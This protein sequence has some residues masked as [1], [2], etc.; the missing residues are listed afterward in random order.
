MPGFDGQELGPANL[1]VVR[2]LKP[3]SG[4]FPRNGSYSFWFS[5]SL[6]MRDSEAS[7][8][9]LI[10]SDTCTRSAQTPPTSIS[11]NSGTRWTVGLAPQAAQASSDS[12]NTYTGRATGYLL[13]NPDRKSVV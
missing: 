8:N 6:P 9:C 1:G 10:M 7:L 4:A 3:V 2:G 11:Q 5:V 12:A 13:G